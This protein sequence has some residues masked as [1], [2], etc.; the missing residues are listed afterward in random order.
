MFSKIDKM[1]KLLK[2]FLVTFFLLHQKLI[3][4]EDIA[5]SIH[6]GY[7]VTFQ[8]IGLL[9][10]IG[11]R[12]YADIMMDMSDIDNFNATE[13][14]SWMID[15]QTDTN[16]TWTNELQIDICLQFEPYFDNFN[17]AIKGIL[18]RYEEKRDNIKTLI[19]IINRSVRTKRAILT[20]LS[21]ALGT[22]GFGYRIYSSYRQEKTD[23]SNCS[24]IG[25]AIH[26][27]SKRQKIFCYCDRRTT[28]ND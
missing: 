21:A 22:I 15:C 23:E 2:G 19:P 5:S 4:T 3:T 20:A 8:G 1:F 28:S 18:D 17:N 13:L 27:L 25:T 9:D 14:I 10:P 11:E 26:M 12:F 16:R 6:P 24:T 7:G